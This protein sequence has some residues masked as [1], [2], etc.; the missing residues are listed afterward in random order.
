MKIDRSSKVLQFSARFSGSL[1]ERRS[2]DFRSLFKL[3]HM[4]LIQ[5]HFLGCELSKARP[6]KAFF[7]LLLKGKI[8]ALVNLQLLIFDF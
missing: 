1:L 6:L 3:A 4:K 8:Q 5:I 7:D 2:F